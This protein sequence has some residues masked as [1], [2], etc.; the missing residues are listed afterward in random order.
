MHEHDLDAHHF[1]PQDYHVLGHVH[2][3]HHTYAGD[4]HPVIVSG[5]DPHAF[6]AHQGDEYIVADS[7]H[8][9][10]GDE[11]VHEL[12]MLSDWM[13]GHGYF[14]DSKHDLDAARL[15]NSFLS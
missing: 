15:S 1:H 11:I 2:D 9:G 7:S 8:A 14:L 5:T 10:I 12:G 4:E 13:Q 6:V 3:T